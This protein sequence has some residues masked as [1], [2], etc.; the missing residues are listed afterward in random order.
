MTDSLEAPELNVR[1]YGTAVTQG[2]KKGFVNPK[3]PKHAIVVDDNPPALKSWRQDVAAA[4][5]K[6]VAEQ[7]WVKLVDRAASVRL[8]FIL[9]RPKSWPLIDTLPRKQPDL[10]KLV[11]AVFDAL[12]AGGAYK[13]DSQVV[14]LRADKRFSTTQQPGVHIRVRDLGR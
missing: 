3:N 4:T 13:D 10:D 11:R 9:D 7:G 5:A 12:K 8:L 6:A 1:V 2:S 14:S